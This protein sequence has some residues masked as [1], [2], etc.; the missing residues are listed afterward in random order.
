MLPYESLSAPD[1]VRLNLFIS[2]I[3]PKVP[4]IETKAAILNRPETISVS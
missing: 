4:G 3:K 1:G 2:I